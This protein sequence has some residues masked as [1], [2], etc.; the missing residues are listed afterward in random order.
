MN[1][2]PVKV[3]NLGDVSIGVGETG[4]DWEP[5]KNNRY[6]AQI[7]PDKAYGFGRTEKEA[8]ENLRKLS[9]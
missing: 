6:F 4:P 9:A 8:L 2:N 7:L 3:I 5:S 1:Q